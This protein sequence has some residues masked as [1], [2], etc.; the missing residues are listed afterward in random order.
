M[1]DFPVDIFRIL[2][3]DSK[4]Y[5]TVPK[6]VY[7]TGQFFKRGFATFDPEF[8][9]IQE[10]WYSQQ[11]DT[12]CSRKFG[13]L[14]ATEIMRKQTIGEIVKVL[15]HQQVS[16]ILR[17]PYGLFQET[18]EKTGWEWASKIPDYQFNS[19]AA[20]RQAMAL[21]KEQTWWRPKRSLAFA[22]C[23]CVQY[24]LPVN[25]DFDKILTDPDNFPN[26]KYHLYEQKMMD[27]IRKENPDI[28]DAIN[29]NIA[30]GKYKKA[31]DLEIWLYE[32]AHKF[33]FA[34]HHINP[35][36]PVLTSAEV[37]EQLR[38]HKKQLLL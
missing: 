11:C 36:S 24:Q 15:P 12:V 38:S 17:V 9:A 30:I 32:A 5:L 20:K 16:P 35:P 21:I 34:K 25:G 18:Y 27:W 33:Y 3:D 13:H 37:K 7:M 4:E 31:S 6:S 29:A 28:V 26:P 19:P 14:K 10:M 22:Q 8:A 1:G 23:L 2:S